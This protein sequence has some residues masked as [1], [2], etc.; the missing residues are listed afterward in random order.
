MN[1]NQCSGVL[2]KNAEKKYR[3]YLVKMN[4]STDVLQK[5]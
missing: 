3:K 2:Y 5:Y 1:I 4:N